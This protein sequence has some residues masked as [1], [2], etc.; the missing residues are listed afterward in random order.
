MKY[1]G[2]WLNNLERPFNN[3]VKKDSSGRTVY[4]PWSYLGKGRAIESAATEIRIRKAVKI[5]NFLWMV[6]V[7]TFGVFFQDKSRLLIFA[8]PAMWLLFYFVSRSVLAGC[9]VSEEKLTFREHNSAVAKNFNEI[10]LFLSLLVTLVFTGVCIWALSAAISKPTA[11][12]DKAIVL[13]GIFFFGLASAN[14]AYVFS[15]KE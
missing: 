11:L 10:A 14:L 9:P 12:G 4:F 15:L 7:L 1:L 2:Q 8:M 3:S 5:Y 13:F 6:L